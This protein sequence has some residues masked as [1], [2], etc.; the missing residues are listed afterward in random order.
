MQEQDIGNP[1]QG[2]GKKE[3]KTNSAKP[4]NRKVKKNKPHRTAT[5]GRGVYGVW[6]VSGTFVVKRRKS[7]NSGVPPHVPPGE[8]KQTR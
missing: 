3:N 8:T 4:F 2:R 5:D 6:G 1:L 7:P